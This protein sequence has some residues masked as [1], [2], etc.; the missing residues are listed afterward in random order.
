MFAEHIVYC[1]ET[2]FVGG[3]KGE[4]FEGEKSYVI[5]CFALHL[6]VIQTI[7]DHHISLLV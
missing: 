7:F 6:A 5:C 1:N 4:V 3:V 2:V